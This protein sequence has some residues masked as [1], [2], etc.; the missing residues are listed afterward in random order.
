V[1]V[2]VAGSPQV[3]PDQEAQHLLSTQ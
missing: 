3:D 1:V 2:D